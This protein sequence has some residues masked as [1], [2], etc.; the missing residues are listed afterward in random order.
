MPPRFSTVPGY[1]Q[2]SPATSFARL[3]GTRYRPRFGKSSKRR[4]NIRAPP[5]PT[6]PIATL[7]T[8]RAA[9]RISTESTN[10][11]ARSVCNAAGAK[12]SAGFRLNAR[13]SSAHG[14][15]GEGSGGSSEKRSRSNLRAAGHRRA[16]HR[17]KVGPAAWSV[18]RKPFRQIGAAP[19]LVRGA[20]LYPSPHHNG[21]ISEDHGA[22]GN[23]RLTPW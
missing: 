12:L 5:F 4:F 22:H 13:R 10:G 9:T 19:S 18:G 20:G 2:K 8:R 14:A 15:S 17:P 6:E 1:T 16:G 3:S 7:G 21:S 11:P 23:G